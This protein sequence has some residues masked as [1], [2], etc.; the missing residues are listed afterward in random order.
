MRL[1][2]IISIS[3]AALLVGL[4]LSAVAFIARPQWFLTVRTVTW[5]AQNF[6]TAYHPSWKALDFNISSLSLPEKQIHLR[7]RDLCFK[8]TDAGVEGCLKDLEILLNV[9]LYF[10]GFKLTRIAKVIV[11]G[12]HLVIDQ[13]VHNRNAP[14]EKIKGLPTSLPNLMPA[15]LHG[16]TIESLKVDLP[17]SEIILSSASVRGELH[18]SVDRSNPLPMTLRAELV[19]SSGTVIRHY[20][21]EASVDSDLLKGQQ[22][23]YLDVL[24]SLKAE[25]VNVQFKSRMEQ[26]KPGVMALSLNASA[27]LPGWRLE[28]D[29]TGSRKGQDFGF[30][31]SA[32]VWN[33][34][35]PVKSIRL[36]PCTLGV[37]LRSDSLAWDT[38]K[39]DGQFE[40]EPKT[41]VAKK[42]RFSMAKKIEGR[43]ALR[44]VST[45]EI[46]AKD[47][48]DADVSV[49]VK[50]LKDWY[51]LYGDLQAHI[52]GRASQMRK[53]KII[54]NVS[55]GL[56]VLKF[57]HLVKFLARTPYSVPA[58]FHVLH[59]PLSVSLK[60]SGD[61]REDLQDFDYTILSDLAAGHQALK[62]EVKGKL[63]ATRLWTP[64]RAFKIETDVILQSIALQLPRFDLKG[65]AAFIPDKRIKTGAEWDKEEVKRKHPV[66]SSAPVTLMNMRVKTAKPVIFYSNLATD[67]IPIGLDITMKIPYNGMGGVVDV[68][69]FRVTIF[70][71]VASI[72]H[73]KFSGHV[74]SPVMDLDGLIIYRAAE[75]KIFIR[76]AGTAQKPQVQ[77]E[78][79][80]PMKPGDIMGML[81]FGKSPSE[82]DSEQQSSAANVQTA[83]ANNA[84]GLTSLYLLASTP[85]DYV[86]YDPTSRTYTVKL[87]IPGG[88]TLLMGSDGQS[89]GLQLRKRIVSNL[90]IKTELSNTQSQ[91]N[92]VTTLLEWYGRH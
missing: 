86:G 53:F 45:P 85:I 76:L 74:G 21:A 18:L 84:F 87:R 58:P 33:P 7:V 1:L 32:G 64:G 90:S 20:H 68:R 41:F 69:P 16:L 82:L 37:R 13:T 10:F 35:G 4:V 60:T 34:S 63:S 57:E 49:T 38:L 14:R 54:N 19:Q 52:S 78:S 31:G 17:D 24:G 50:P 71:R 44:A 83:I 61:P 73:I 39:L 6:G 11:S 55:L 72:D 12:D 89:S 43:L 8:N 62:F 80:P 75:A 40:L 26:G 47:H 81:L 67:P 42:V 77:L 25:G 70:R 23:T 79:D 5:V 27:R 46:L 48:F 28:A 2:K 3:T 56:K 91:G 88:A 9:R 30:R 29:L 59:G 36:N 22:F 92:I 15:A 51:E 66:K 65:M